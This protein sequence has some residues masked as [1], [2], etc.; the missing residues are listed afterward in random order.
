MISVIFTLLVCSGNYGMAKAVPTIEVPALIDAVVDAIAGD[1]M[2]AR[3]DVQIAIFNHTMTAMV[4]TRRAASDH[5]RISKKIMAALVDYIGDLLTDD[6][7][8]FEIEI[9]RARSSS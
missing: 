5:A 6:F 3:L 8:N 2:Q 1:G 4:E 9:K 7:A